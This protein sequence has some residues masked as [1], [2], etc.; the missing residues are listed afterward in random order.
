[1]D[2]PRLR[3]ALRVAVLAVGLAGHVAAAGVVV[4]MGPPPDGSHATPGALLFLVPLVG[5][6]ATHAVAV[7][8]YGLPSGEGRLRVGPLADR[9]CVVRLL[10]GGGA[11]VLVGVPL[12]SG[13][14]TL[15]SGTTAVV[16]WVLGVGLVGGGTVGVA[17]GGL[18]TAARAGADGVREYLGTRG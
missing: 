16:I 4:W 13:A 9:S 15:S 8:G 3:A 17:L 7:V 18:W 2:R 10:V 6:P 14:A 11:S 1:V 12:L 5:S